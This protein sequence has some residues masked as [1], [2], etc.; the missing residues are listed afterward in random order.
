M[1]YARQRDVNIL[2]FVGIIE[3]NQAL[4]KHPRCENSK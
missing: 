4:T 1:S 3:A 2:R